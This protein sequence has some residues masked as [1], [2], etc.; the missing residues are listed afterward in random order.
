MDDHST[1]SKGHPLSVPLGLVFQL[2]YTGSCVFV[3]EAGRFPCITSSRLTPSIDVTTT[4]IFPSWKVFCV[5]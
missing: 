1:K 4:Y 3:L 2:Q 5:K